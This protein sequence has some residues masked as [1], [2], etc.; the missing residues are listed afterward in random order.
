MEKFKT[1]SQVFEQY[2]RALKTAFPKLRFR[3]ST[4]DPTKWYGEDFYQNTRYKLIYRAYERT[5]EYYKSKDK[6]RFIYG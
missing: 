1:N 6:N 4:C 3:G 2:K 5:T